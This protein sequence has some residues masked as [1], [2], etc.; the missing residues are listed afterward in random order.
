MSDYTETFGESH[1]PLAHMA[2]V[3]ST[4][5][6]NSGYVNVGKYHRIAVVLHA[7]VVGTTLDIDIEVANDNAAANVFTLKHITQLVAADDDVV[8]VIDIRGD[9]LGKPSGATGQN[10]DWLNVEV[11]PSGASTFSCIVYGI[12]PRFEPVDATLWHE[13]V[14]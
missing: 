4:T 11:T 7:L 3:G 6:Q 10:Y 1:A 13:Q 8:V 9:E 5:E 2:R 14:H 12:V